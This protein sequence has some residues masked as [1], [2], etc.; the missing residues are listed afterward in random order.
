MKNRLKTFP[1]GELLIKENSVS[2][3]MF[4]IKEG[5]VRVYKDYLGA[6]I[7]LAVLG[8]GEVFGE[9]S[10]FD[11]EPRSASCETLTHLKAIVI[12]GDEASSDIKNLP[13]WIFPIFKAVFRRFREADAKIMVL[14]SMN[15]FQKK[16]FKTDNVAQTIY[17]ELI[18]FIKTITLL[19]KNKTAENTTNELLNVNKFLTEFDGMVGS[20]FIG[21]KV[22]WKLFLQY[23]YANNRLAAKENKL[24]LNLDRI[25]NLLGYLQSE[26]EKSSYLLLSHTALAI[27]D[28][29]VGYVE[30][31]HL[32]SS[33]Q[34]HSKMQLNNSNL[35]LEEIPLYEQGLEELKQ[36][37]F[38]SDDCKKFDFNI[39][40]LFQ[41]HQYQKF[42]KSFDH[43]SYNLG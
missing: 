9:L 32:D 21:A 28:R 19:Y 42:I 15:E 7:T 14:Q 29:I 8:P 18:R 10:F 24:N 6:K 17:S 39:D 12:E 33:S 38:M 23:D 25:E 31:H 1:P 35:Q 27:I 30:S 36:S 11:A 40:E 37:G 41:M 13:Q 20:R 16:A 34:P 43:S 4:I 5:N 3:K 22:F 26:T 2:R